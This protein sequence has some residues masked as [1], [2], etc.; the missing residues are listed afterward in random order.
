MLFGCITI[1]E[2][3]VSGGRGLPFR[4]CTRR[5]PRRTRRS[6]RRWRPRV[7]R[8]CCGCGT[9]CP[10]STA[11]RRAA[12]VTA[13]STPRASTPCAP[14]GG[15]WP[16]ASRRP[17]HWG[18]SSDSPVVVYFL[19]GR[20]APVFVE[21]PRQVSAYHYPR[22]YGT[23]SPVFSRAALLRQAQSLTLFISGTASI[24]G[25]RSLHLGDTAAQTR[26]TLTNIEALLGEANRTAR[27]ARTSTWTRSPT[28]STCAGRRT[29]RSSSASS[30]TR[31]GL[32]GA[33]HLSAGG[34]LPPGPPGRDR[35]DRNMPACQRCLRRC[36]RC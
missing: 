24:V 21:N 2:A 13:S 5:P 11:I 26:E 29:C 18:P 23:H 6:A 14:A 12:S 20:V 27:A 25:H 8:T 16:A 31:P 3:D 35:S 4:R 9:T 28:R 34:H 33:D 17:P 19:A 15:R 1:A 22:E 32:A 10:T 7:I 36:A 30:P